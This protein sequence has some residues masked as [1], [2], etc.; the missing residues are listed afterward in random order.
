MKLTIEGTPDE[1]A[2][3]VRSTATDLV[4]AEEVETP[5]LTAKDIRR[6]VA[7]NSI[8][9]LDALAT[10]APR[11]LTYQEVQDATGLTPYE[12]RGGL[13]GLGRL[14]GG[15]PSRALFQRSDGKPSF[16]WMTTDAAEQW[17]ASGG[18]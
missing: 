9:I 18:E 8:S 17:L 11:C 4:A 7:A 14:T 10:R 2:S 5:N 3:W 15:D 13:V 16:Y 1:I 6:R 12:V